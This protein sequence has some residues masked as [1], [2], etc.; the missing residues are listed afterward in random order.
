LATTVPRP[1]DDRAVLGRG[2]TRRY[3]GFTAV[4]AIDLTVYAGECFGLLG[5]NGAGKSSTMRMLSC[6][7]TPTAGEL[8]VLGRDPRREAAAIRGEL[9]IVHQE[10]NLDLDI[11]VVENLTTYARYFG[12]SR[13][14]CRRRAAEMLEFAQLEHKARSKTEQLSGGMQRRLAIVRALVNTPRMVFLD[15]PT[16]GLD[17]QMR[18]VVWQRLLEL[19]HRRTT[20]VLTTHYMEEAEQLCD[21][22]VIMDRGR[23]VAEGPPQLLIKE[24]A[25]QDVVEL[26]FADGRGDDVPGALRGITDQCDVLD[27]RVLLFVADGDEAAAEVHRRGLRPT[28]LTV[29]R[30][31]LQDVFLRLTGRPLEE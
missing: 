31:T 27:D 1:L 24:Y 12:F 18:E 10:N 8:S 16:T 25:G 19:K 29:R 3:G 28:R 11:K 15:E 26:W 20:L 17:P 2:L 4:D 13:A 23:V 21:R 30:A 9:G 6:I 22:I 7:S 14:E 5:P